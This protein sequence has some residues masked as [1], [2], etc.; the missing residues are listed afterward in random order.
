MVKNLNKLAREII[1]NN[2]YVTMATSD[3]KGKP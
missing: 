3:E 1:E 2:Q